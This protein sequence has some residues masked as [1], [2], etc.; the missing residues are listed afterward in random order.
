MQRI[1]LKTE[2]IIQSVSM[3]SFQHNASFISSGSNNNPII[4]KKIQ[5]TGHFF[6]VHVEEILKS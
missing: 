4:Y 3:T 1:K 6:Y 2:Y 5:I